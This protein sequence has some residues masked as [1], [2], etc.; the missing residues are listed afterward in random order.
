MTHR[1]STTRWRRFVRYGYPITA[2]YL[3]VMATLTVVLLIV[4]PILSKC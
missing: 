4:N 1:P 2:V 3:A